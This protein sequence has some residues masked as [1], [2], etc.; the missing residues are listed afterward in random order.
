M[1]RVSFDRHQ[2]KRPNLQLRLAQI[3]AASAVALKVALALE[4]RGKRLSGYSPAPGR[5]RWRASLPGAS[6]GC[7]PRA[8]PNAIIGFAPRHLLQ[9]VAECVVVASLKP[10][11]LSLPLARLDQ[12][13]QTPRALYGRLPTFCAPLVTQH[14][15]LILALPRSPQVRKLIFNPFSHVYLSMC[16]SRTLITATI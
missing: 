3:P 1:P 8:L 10:T 15:Q 2:S 12:V 13:L 11:L 14:A 7:W 16:P 6:G 4:G 5:A 9:P